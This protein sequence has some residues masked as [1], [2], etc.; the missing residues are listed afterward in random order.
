MT[1]PDLK[2]EVEKP[3]SEEQVVDNLS[4][5]LVEEFGEF[6][7]KLDLPKFQFPSIELL[8]GYNN[9]NININKEISISA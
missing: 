9:E 1:L 5:K 7:P 6:D 2:M 4:N 3:I 8:N